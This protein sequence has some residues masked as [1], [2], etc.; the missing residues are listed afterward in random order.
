[1]KRFFFLSALFH[2]A[3]LLLLFS[4]EAPLADR[5]LPKNILAVS[6]VDRI[7]EK[8]E[9]K[10]SQGIKPIP[11]NNPTRKKIVEKKDVGATWRVSPTYPEE[12]KEKPTEEKVETLL[13]EAK[14]EKPKG[15]EKVP[16]EERVLTARGEE[17]L[18]VQAKLGPQTV[19]GG[20]TKELPSPAGG[21][22]ISGGKENSR[23]AFLVPP[24]PMKRE[25]IQSG[26]GWRGSRPT[27]GE[28][29][30]AWFG[31]TGNFSQEGDS[32]LSEIMGR[33]ERAKRYPKVARRMGIEGKTTVR[34][35]LKPNG[36]V[37]SAEILGSSGSDILDQASLETVQRATPLPYKEGWLKVIIIFKIL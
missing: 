14:E 6:L 4:W 20:N 2:G 22:P 10:K 16:S 21:P 15:E 28:G 24:D 25:G 8:M 35:K 7:E 12:K 13:I 5:L 37:D 27:A 33:I 34:F 36:K 9:E 30:S 32:I 18:I 31:S 11:L 19:E 3:V 1:M 29:G 26:K 17:P 23:A